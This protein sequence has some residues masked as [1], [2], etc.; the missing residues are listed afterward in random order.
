MAQPTPAQ[1]FL[2]EADDLLTRVEEIALELQEGVAAGD[3]IHQLFRAFHTIK[4][5]GAMFGFDAVAAFTHHV[6]TTLDHV[7][8]GSIPVTRELIELIL[9]ARDQIK[10]MLAS[11]QQS[12][13][14]TGKIT[15]ALQSLPRPGSAGAPAPETKSRVWRI[16]FR[17]SLDLFLSGSNPALLL[18][19]LRSFGPCTVLMHDE[20]VPPLARIQPDR[21]YLWWTITLQTERSVD[22]IRDVFLFVSDESK[23]EIEPEESTQTA[24]AG[25]AAAEPGKASLSESTVRV[26]SDRLDR[27]VNLVGEL[28]VNQSRLRQAIPRDAAAELAAPVEEIERLVD[29]LRDHVLAIR[30]MPLETTFRRFK[31]LVHDL[32]AELGKEIDLIT[33]GGKT[34]PDKTVLDQLADPLVHLVRNSID[35]GIERAEERLARNKPR[36]G[37][38]RMSACHTGASVVVTIADDGRGLDCDAIRAKAI[39]K[40]LIA[41]DARLSEKETF[42]LIFQ[43]G[44]STAREVTTVSGRGVGMDV[45]KRQIDALRGEV[46]VASRPGAGASVS[47]T[48]PLTLAIID[49]LLVAAAGN[50]FIIP[51]AAVTENVE[52]GA[53]ERQ[54]HNSHNLI[55]VRGQMISYVRLREVFRLPGE[56]PAMEKIVVVR[57]GDARV[58]DRGGQDPGQPPDRNPTIGQVL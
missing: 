25:P 27:L 5:S 8:E 33:E 28:V 50:R 16:L 44:F 22:E 9:Q 48:L 56:P 55:A 53:A 31:R 12:S 18:D 19:E 37:T 3:R 49:G 36:R 24:P 52:S 26:P 42:H 11:G 39:E 4:G 47:L 35:H 43:P 58:R 1:L 29:E 54:R 41:T 2:L 46:A 51:M 21:C 40:H 17:P 23:I 57:I 6:E 45:V 13:G 32:A 15:A 20:D 30:M 7:R 10:A 38:V 14:N 34:E